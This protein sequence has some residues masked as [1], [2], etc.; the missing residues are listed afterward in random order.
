MADQIDPRLLAYMSN[1]LGPR[2]KPEHLEGAM[3]MEGMKSLSKSMTP[4]QPKQPAQ[5][6]IGGQVLLN[7]Q[8]PGP[9]PMRSGMQ[10]DQLQA[11]IQLLSMPGF[12]E[13]LMRAGI[14][15]PRSGSPPQG[16]PGVQGPQFG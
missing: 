3:L 10:P 15:P 12:G 11:L 14:V 9:G 16:I 6:Q 7:K 2:L 5:P 13:Q 4:A 8:V 1:V